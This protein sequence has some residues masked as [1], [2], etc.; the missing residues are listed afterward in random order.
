MTTPHNSSNNDVKTLYISGLP[1]DVKERE[2]QL[3]CRPFNGFDFCNLNL[4]GESPTAFVKFKDRDSA[5]MAR[6]QLDGREFD[7]NRPDEKLRVDFARSDTLKKQHPEDYGETHDGKRRRIGTPSPKF[8]Y[9]NDTYSYPY[10]FPHSYG[11][12]YYSYQY[13]YSG[14]H[15]PQSNT[16]FVG[17]LP[18]N[19]TESDIVEIFKNYHGYKTVRTTTFKNRMVAFVQFAED[20]YAANALSHAQGQTRL[21]GNTLKIEFAQG[22]RDNKHRHSKTSQSPRYTSPRTPSP[23]SPRNGD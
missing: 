21:S 6:Q 23:R 3:L 14:D 9:P 2:V 19:C 11:T 4:K 1:H 12:D 18:P 7:L 8:Y 5:A 20:S 13:P 10:R 16:L 17:N 22:T 15:H